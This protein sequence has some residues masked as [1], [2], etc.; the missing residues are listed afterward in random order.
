MYICTECKTE[1]KIKPDYCE[2]GNDLFDEILEKEQKTKTQTAFYEKHP[3]IKKLLGSFDILSI[4]IFATCI[5]LSILVWAFLGETSPEAKQAQKKVATET[6]KETAVKT[7][8]PTLDSF[9]DDTK[10]IVPEVKTEQ[11]IDETQ[12]EEHHRI[13]D[14]EEPELR[15]PIARPEPQI[16]R[17]NEQK[18]PVPQSIAPPKPK[19]T[20]QKK[21]AKPAASNAE[22]A[23]YKG[24]LRDALFSHLEVTSIQGSG[25]CQVEFSVSKSGKL[26]NRRFSKFSGNKSLDD[27]VYRMLMSLPQFEPP[28]SGYNGQKIRLNFSFED[29]YYEI[30]Y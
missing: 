12:I 30:S 11:P 28:P 10:P 13:P 16:I 23:Q 14:L 19:T 6:K 25:N 20:Q 27:A 26:E 1:Y 18:R 7:N 29:G 3:K 2:C 17:I 22:L 24:E 4:A 8:I 15:A 21:T 5:I 9:W